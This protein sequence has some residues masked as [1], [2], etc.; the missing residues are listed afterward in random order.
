MMR[1]LETESPDGA[2]ETI[3]GVPC[4]VFRPDAAR[5]VYLHFHGGAM[6]L[7]SPRMNDVDNARTRVGARR[8]RRVGRLP[9]RA[10]APVPRRQRRLPRG[11]AG[12]A[13]TARRS[14]AS[15]SAASRPAPTTR[16][17][18]C[19]ASA[20]SSTPSTACVGANLVF[21]VYD[22]SGTPSNQLGQPPAATS[23]TSSRTTPPGGCSRTTC[24]AARP[25]R[26]A[27]PDCSPLYAD[28][29]D[30]PPALFTRRLGRPPARRQPVHGRPL[31]GL[32]QRR[33]ARRVPRLHPRVH[34]LP[35][36]A[37]QAGQRAH[38]RLRRPLVRLTPASTRSDPRAHPTAGAAGV[39]LAGCGF[40]SR[41][42]RAEVTSARSS[43][44]PPPCATPGTRSVGRPRAEA[45]ATVAAL[46]FAVE[47]AGLDVARRR[48]ALADRLPSDHGAAAPATPRAPLRRVLR[49]GGRAGHGRGRRG[50]WSSPSAR[51]SSSTRRP[52]SGSCPSPSSAASRTWSSGSAGPR[53]PTPSR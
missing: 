49:R 22:L 36:R 47:P 39:T 38:R 16:R 52:S 4:R 43:P 33:R 28:L 35:D 24:R 48:A 44:W 37:G 32:G 18:P 50:P 19:C 26:P 45:C 12:G 25:T 10:R 14:A 46:G 7:G 17:S 15:S 23:P 29:H 3:A 40:S 2:D 30:L 21:G 1:L 34:R 9:A 13:R 31:A 27:R 8:R 11:G 53:P 41:R 42:R 51:T 6:V 5:G 20:T